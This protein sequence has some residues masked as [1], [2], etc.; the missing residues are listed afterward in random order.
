MRD[1]YS[2][3]NSNYLER[4]AAFFGNIRDFVKY[5]HHKNSLLWLVARLTGSQENRLITCLKGQFQNTVPVLSFLCFLGKF[6]RYKNRSS[7]KIFPMPG[8]QELKSSIRPA[9]TK[10]RQIILTFLLF[11]WLHIPS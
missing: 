2:L 7:G 3:P 4:L 8:N 11:L 5:Q 10:R 9:W 1:K 6:T